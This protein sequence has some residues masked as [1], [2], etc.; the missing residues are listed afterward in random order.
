MHDCK[1]QYQ[2]VVTDMTSGPPC[3][4]SR[5]GYFGDI[6]K[7]FNKIYFNTEEV[8]CKNDIGDIGKMLSRTSLIHCRVRHDCPTDLEDTEAVTEVISIVGADPNEA[9]DGNGGGGDEPTFDDGSFFTF[10]PEERHRFRLST[11]APRKP[12]KMNNKKFFI[13][14]TTSRQQ[15]AVTTAGRRGPFVVAEEVVQRPR[16]L[17]DRPLT[18]MPAIWFHNR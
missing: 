13:S 6:G 4:Y 8:M 7:N 11:P 1:Y 18:S 10:V 14:T 9:G 3:T 12:S 5:Y 17:Q 2:L 15:P 16:L